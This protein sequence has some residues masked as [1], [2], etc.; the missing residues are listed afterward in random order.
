MPAMTAAAIATAG[1]SAAIGVTVVSA[2]A[3]VMLVVLA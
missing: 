1:M 3:V 2:P